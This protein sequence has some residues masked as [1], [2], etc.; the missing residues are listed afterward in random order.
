M[1]DSHANALDNAVMAAVLSADGP[2]SIVVEAP[3]NIIAPT[4]GYYNTATI[5]FTLATTTVPAAN[6]SLP[7]CQR[8]PRLKIRNHL[9]TP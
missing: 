4:E 7:L 2:P 3:L 6:T 9:L 1:T 5:T 8:H